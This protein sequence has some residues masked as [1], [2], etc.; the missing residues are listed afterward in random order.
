[1]G[2]IQPAV[3]G[4]DAFAGI[5]AARR[6]SPADSI[7]REIC[8]IG[9]F[10]R[11]V[12]FLGPAT[13]A[14]PSGSHG[15]TGADEIDSIFGEDLLPAGTSP[16]FFQSIDDE[17]RQIGFI[18]AQGSGNRVVDDHGVTAQALSAVARTA[19]LALRAPPTPLA[20]A[21]HLHDTVVQRLAGVSFLL[22]AEEPLASDERKVCREEISA[23]LDELR[24][25]LENTLLRATSDATAIERE[26]EALSHE[27]PDVAVSLP[28]TE[29][30]VAV[31]RF[32][33][34]ETFVS[35]GLRNARQHA[36][37][38]RV[39]VEVVEDS[40]TLSVTIRNDRAGQSRGGGCGIGLRLLE[41]EASLAGGAV[42]G[43]ADEMEGWWRLRLTLPT[44]S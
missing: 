33:V 1:M 32:P 42:D 41:L 5:P 10:Q 16:A 6:H 23:A 36:S 4:T 24:D 25:G 14:V 27:H 9:G 20:M 12:L 34:I 17:G 22:A 18:L 7:C 2:P 40:E 35:E 44:S 19:A 43:S 30:A 13:E 39:L 21:R 3:R 29:M 26:I 37:P 38:T 8:E 11:A 28:T 15:L 31:H